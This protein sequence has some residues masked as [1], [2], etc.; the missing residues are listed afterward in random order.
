MLVEDRDQELRNLP[1]WLL[2]L[3]SEVIVEVFNYGLHVVYQA[4]EFLSVVWLGLLK[5]C[6]VALNGPLKDLKPDFLINRSLTH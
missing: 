1:D 2:K 5:R 6:H 3:L 4:R